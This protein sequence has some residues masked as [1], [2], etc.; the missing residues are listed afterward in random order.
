MNM[1]NKS[2]SFSQLAINNS[3]KEKKY[4]EINNKNSN[5]FKEW[6]IPIVSALALALLINKFIYFNVYIPSGSMIPTL[7]INDKLVVTRVYNKE[8]LKEGDIVVF[9]SEEYNERLVKR[10]IGL[11]G[12][13]IEIKNGVVF[14]NGQKINEDYVKNK[15]D[16][17]GT[18]EVPQGKYFFLGDNRPDSADSRRWK[19][20]Y[21]DGSDIEGK[22]Q[23]RFSPIK[24]F[25]TVK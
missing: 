3:K 16:F 12:D 25:G 6:I 1:N 14:R 4:K 22:I 2:T 24:D 11:P 20:P 15:D 9:F 5:F 21:I 7:N 13:K 23:F 18:Y 8:N 10:L 17:N 19:N